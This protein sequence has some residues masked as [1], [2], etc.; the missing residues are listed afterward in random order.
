MAFTHQK[1]FTLSLA[2]RQVP[3]SISVLSIITDISFLFAFFLPPFYVLGVLCF[4][5]FLGIL[6]YTVELQWLEHLSDN[7]N[8]FE[9]GVV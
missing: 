5:T 7:E 9:T 3:V 6:I 8:M 4:V 1:H 2:S